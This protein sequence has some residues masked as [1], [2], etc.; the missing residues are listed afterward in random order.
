MEDFKV[1]DMMI[2]DRNRKPFSVWSIYVGQKI[3]SV[4]FMVSAFKSE[5]VSF[6]LKVA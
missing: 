6:Y 5:I 2:E 1:I 3:V 4:E